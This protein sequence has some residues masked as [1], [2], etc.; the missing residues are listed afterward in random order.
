M[1]VIPIPN[2]LVAFNFPL[3]DCDSCD[4]REYCSPV[5]DGET[6]DFQFR[7]TPCGPNLI[8]DPTFKKISDQLV[9]NPSFT[10]SAAGWTLGSAQWSY[11]SNHVHYNSAGGG[12]G[13]L[14]QTIATSLVPNKWYILR[15]TTSTVTGTL[16]LIIDLGGTAF[17]I[18]VSQAGSM[19]LRLQCGSSGNDL[20][21]GQNT[22]PCTFNIDDVEL[23][24]IAPC[25]SAAIGWVY[26]VNG[27]VTH[28]P[29]SVNGI[30]P[31]PTPVIGGKRYQIK[32]NIVNYVAGYI[33]IT[34]GSTVSDRISSEGL[35]T[36]WVES[37]GTGFTITPSSDFAGSITFVECKQQKNDFTFGV[38]D[39]DDETEHTTASIA[40]YFHD[41]VTVKLNPLLYIPSD[42]CFKII[43]HD[44]CS[45]YFD[46]LIVDGTFLLPLAF[47]DP[48]TEPWWAANGFFTNNTSFHLA[49]CPT[50]LGGLL[51]QYFV[52]GPS[53]KAGLF[54]P[55]ITKFAWHIKVGGV[56]NP[57]AN[58]VLTIGG[59]ILTTITSP[60]DY[61]GITSTLPLSNNEIRIRAFADSGAA[62]SDITTVTEIEIYP[63]DEVDEDYFSQCFQVTVGES[64]IREVMA[65]SDKPAFGFAFNVPSSTD[66]LNVFNLRSWIMFQLFDPI[67]PEEQTNYIF[68]DGTKKITFASSDELIDMRTDFIPEWAHRTLRIMKICDHLF[69]SGIEYVA[70]EGDYIPE[71][72]EGENLRLSSVQLQL[73]P[74]TIL[75][76]NN[77]CE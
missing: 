77:N 18:G 17:P 25:W 45:F 12:S 31:T 4:D 66:P 6:I 47:N 69:V 57:T 8:C 73:R 50:K 1:S 28:I 26:E 38:L 72:L 32:V 3:N 34:C 74:K 20:V 23:Y 71:Y 65:Y 75:L 7:Q 30:S 21:I 33:T 60:G 61:S 29:G 35:T 43:I 19:L 16:D 42:H 48:P 63:I 56:Y 54:L 64:C 14:S 39:L 58:I 40:S 9:T 41:F 46:D 22:S 52:N 68:S 62:D 24:E 44:L 5:P 27:A 59:R 67:F 13:S 49:Q 11:A 2:Q 15:L 55:G 36:V 37:N 51:R 76:Q 53:F 70:K 10:G